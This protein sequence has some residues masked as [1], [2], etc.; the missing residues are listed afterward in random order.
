MRNPS[1]TR[2]LLLVILFLVGKSHLAWS[3]DLNENESD[4]SSKESN[5]LEDKQKEKDPWEFKA[6]RHHMSLLGATGLFNIKEAGSAEA[7]TFGVG[8]HTTYFKYKNYLFKGDENVNM[9][10]GIHLRVTPIDFLEIYAGIGGRAN[11]NDKVNPE[12]F[13][14]L[15]D[16]KIGVKGYFSPFNGLTIGGLLECDFIN[17]LGEVAFSFKGTSFPLGLLSSF[18]F[19]ELSDK[20]PVRAHLNAVYKFDNSYKSIES[21]ELSNGGCGTDENNDG[22]LDYDGCVN[23]AERVAFNINRNDQLGIGIGVDAALPYITPLIEY[24]LE[25]P[26]NRQ[27]FECGFNIP[28]N[29][30]DSCVGEQKGSSM[31]QW[32]TFGVRGLPPID[33]LAI[34][35]GVDVGLTGW[36]PTVHE[37]V[38]TAPYR[39]IFGLSYSFDPFIETIEPPPPPPPPTPPPPPPPPLPVVR[40]FVH[41]AALAKEPIAGATITYI[42]RDVNPQ[43]SKSDGS[44][45]SCALDPGQLIVSIRAD[46]YEEATF[47]IEIPD[48]EDKEYELTDSSVSIDRYAPQEISIDCPLVALPSKGK[49]IINIVDGK[50][51]PMSHVTITAEGPEKETGTTDINGAY[52]MDIEGGSY[53]IIVEKEGYF[54]KTVQSEVSSAKTTEVEVEMYSKHKKANVVVRNKRIVIMKKIH[55]APDSDKIK[56]SSFALMDEIVDVITKH[57]ELSLIEIQGHTDNTGKRQYNIE[58]SQRRADAVQS[59]LVNAGISGLRLNAKGYGPDKPVEPNIS[60]VGRSR[61]RRVEFR[62]RKRED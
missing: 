30:V 47:T 40:G 58:L 10:G 11:Y 27:G 12:L 57:S 62:I 41:N 22:Q 16:T 5:E 9:W 56:A 36:G 45:Q 38:P 18:D 6:T 34:D 39:I 2:V 17:P 23:P 52:T 4:Y 59:Y 55:F 35:F 50:K 42:D 1:S 48:P 43:V 28:G 46:G 61:N 14:A 21:L 7:G 44:F 53:S 31:R 8:I 49:L 54:R 15:G 24:H 51:S 60:T 3:G 26:I 32:M 37:L 20:I 25:I 33:S 19:K 13:Q 29:N